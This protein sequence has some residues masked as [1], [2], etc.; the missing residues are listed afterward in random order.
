[1]CANRIPTLILGGLSEDQG[2]GHA[3]W[4]RCRV[5]HK[6]ADTV[7]QRKIDISGSELQSGSA[8]MGKGGVT[9]GEIRCHRK[10]RE[11]VRRKF[12]GISIVVCDALRLKAIDDIA[13][14]LIAEK[15]IKQAERGICDADTL[16]SLVLKDLQPDKS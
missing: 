10:S 15:I 8:E 14:R 16:V 2:H 12:E 9:A 1:M 5:E 6:T 4:R 7:M 11:I 3:E 13:T